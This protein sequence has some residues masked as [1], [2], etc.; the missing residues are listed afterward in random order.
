MSR[1]TESVVEEAA[2]AWFDELG[3]SV[4]SG[5]D[6]QPDSPLRNV[7]TGVRHRGWEFRERFEESRPGIAH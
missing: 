3:Y 2:L 1:F 4:M 5:A 6:L 7:S